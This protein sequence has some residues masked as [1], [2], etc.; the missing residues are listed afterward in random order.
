MQDKPTIEESCKSKVCTSRRRQLCCNS[1]LIK[2]PNLEYRWSDWMKKC[3]ELPNWR[4]K[5]RCWLKRSKTDT[6]LAPWI[7]CL[8]HGQW[9]NTRSNG[10]YTMIQGIIQESLTVA[11]LVDKRKTPR[12][13]TWRVFDLMCVNSVSVYA[14]N[15]K[16]FQKK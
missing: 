2:L 3:M 7:I 14:N 5:A 15:Q 6:K 16:C 1:H 13:F 10:Y 12:E 8:T 9:T 4:C 11:I